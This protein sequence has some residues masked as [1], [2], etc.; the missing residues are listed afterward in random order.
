M[1]ESEVIENFLSIVVDICF[2]MLTS[3]S[4]NNHMNV[5]TYEHETMTLTPIICIL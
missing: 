4:H 2:L 3:M 5:K 1:F